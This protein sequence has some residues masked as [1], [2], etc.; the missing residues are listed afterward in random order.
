MPNPTPR[1]SAH[2]LPNRECAPQ[3]RRR[4]KPYRP[5]SDA[6][7]RELYYRS[8]G[9]RELRTEAE[10]LIREHQGFIDDLFNEHFEDKGGD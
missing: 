5:L 8:L 7:C 3:S 6:R 1:R 2:A 9:I 4:P 10:M